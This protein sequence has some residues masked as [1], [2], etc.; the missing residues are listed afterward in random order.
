MKGLEQK[1]FHKRESLIQSKHNFLIE[2]KM[3]QYFVFGTA[4]QE[5]VGIN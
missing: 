2:I 5:L 3:E 4:V 1:S